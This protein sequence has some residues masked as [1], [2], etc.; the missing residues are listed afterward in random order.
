MR[1]VAQRKGPE[2]LI[3]DNRTLLIFS[4]GE[5]FDGPYYCSDLVRS[6]FLPGGRYFLFN[7][8]CN[9]YNGQLL[10]DTISGKYAP[11][12]DNTR[13]YI[14]F[15]TDTYPHYNISG[16]GIS[17]TGLVEVNFKL[18]YHFINL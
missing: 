3:I 4:V 18:T 10:I 5:S 14:T 1:L 9:N 7:V 16:G 17:P 8:H 2:E 15:N 11:L 6:Q 12:P 13:I